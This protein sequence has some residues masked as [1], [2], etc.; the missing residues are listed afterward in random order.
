MTSKCSS[1]QFQTISFPNILC[2]SRQKGEENEIISNTVQINN[3]K[4]IYF[5]FCM[6]QVHK[7]EKFWYPIDGPTYIVLVLYILKRRKEL[8]NK[9]WF[10]VSGKSSYKIVIKSITKKEKEKTEKEQRK[11]MSADRVYLTCSKHARSLAA[12]W[13]FLC[14]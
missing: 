12:K 4:I 10:I 5:L 6:W 8:V 3:K 1:S 11:E 9:M 7:T 2:C 14:F 13:E